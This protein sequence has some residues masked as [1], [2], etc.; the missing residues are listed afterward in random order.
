MD[1]TV[2]PSKSADSAPQRLTVDVAISG[3]GFVGG[4]LAVGLARHGVR[5]A[6]IDRVDPAVALDRGFDGRAFAVAL[7]SQRLLAALDIWPRVKITEPIRH[8][9][10][11]DG[12]SLFFLHYD[13]ADLGDEPLGYMVENR[14]LRTALASAITAESE[15]IVR[16]TPATVIGLT[17]GPDR[18]TLALADGR[19]VDASMVIAADG[20]TSTLRELSGIPLVGWKYDQVGIV[21]TIGHA[22][23]H[24]GIAHEHFLPAGPFAILPLADEYGADGTSQHRSSL[25]WTERADAAA[26]YLALP[27]KTFLAEIDRRV[28]GFLGELSL[29]GPRFSHPLGLQF[30]SRYVDRRL[31]LTGD[32]AHGIHPIAG[33]GV[34][35]G[36]RDVAALIEIIVDAKRLGLDLAHPAGLA[37]YERWR[38][39]D[40]LLMATACDLLNRLFSNDVAPIRIARDIG[41]SIVNRLRPVKKLLMRHAMGT[42]GDLPRLMRGEAL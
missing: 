2:N 29:M 33:Q 16:L 6:M 27:E 1:A 11:S 17:Q 34:N 4:A 38:R 31:V 25:V 20:R 41:L 12:D 36:Y 8:I 28:G 19:M 14:V 42:V 13:H 24:D 40:N 22:R 5:V 21:A 7:S 10:V 18:A 30:A 23:P 35:L 39:A 37:R 26:G 15:R 3:G 32:A 9:R